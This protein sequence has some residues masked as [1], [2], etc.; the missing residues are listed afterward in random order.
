MVQFIQFFL[1]SFAALPKLSVVLCKIQIKSFT[2]INQSDDL[3]ILI[4]FELITFFL[5]ASNFT[6]F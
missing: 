4:K 5:T 6:K 3:L 2:L 1:F